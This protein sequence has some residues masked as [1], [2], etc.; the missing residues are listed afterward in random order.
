MNPLAKFF[1]LKHSQGILAGT[2]RRFPNSVIGIAEHVPFVP[3]LIQILAMIKTDVGNA[4][5]VLWVATIHAVV[6]W[7]LLAPVAIFLTYKILAP[8]LRRLS[9]TTGL[10]APELPIL[11]AGKQV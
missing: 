1:D 11:V 9:V 7:A 6:V 10:S 5:K 8:I 3:A 4:I 2:D